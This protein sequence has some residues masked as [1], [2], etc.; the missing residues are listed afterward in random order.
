MQDPKP[1]NPEAWRTATLLAETPDSLVLAP[2]LR[3]NIESHMTA[4]VPREACGLVAGEAPNI[5]VRVLRAVNEAREIDRYGIGPEQQ[6]RLF[7]EIW[8]RREKLV[9]IYHSHVGF[10]P[11]PI[12]I[13]RLGAYYPEAL[14]LIGSVIGHEVTLHAYRINNG[15]HREVDIQW[16]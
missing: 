9:A 8:R 14:Y 1:D 3:Q 12:P 2:A 16:R 15:T 7:N 6:V 10:G 4:E 13:D 11:E 5:A